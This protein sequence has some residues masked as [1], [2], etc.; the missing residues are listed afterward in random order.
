MSKYDV[1]TVGSSTID[2]F[3]HTDPGQSELLNVHNHADVAYPLGA[4][5]LIKELNFFTG[6]GGTN[7]AVAFSRLGLKSAFLGMV[8]N[9]D[10]GN[11]I[12]KNLSDEKV[13][14]IGKQSGISGY[15]VILDSVHD[16]RTIFTFKGCNDDFDLR[17]IELKSLDAGWF[18]FSSMM[19]H[20][21]SALEKLSDYAHK[22]NIKI[23]FNPSLYLAKKGKGY[24]KNVLKNCEILTYAKEEAQELLS[25]PTENIFIL[26][27]E[28]SKLGPKIVAITDGKNGANCYDSYENIFYSAKPPNNLKIVETTG[29]GDAFA[30]GF[31]AAKIL[32][33]GTPYAMK[34]GMINAESLISGL[35]AKTKLLTSIAFQIAEKNKRP[36]IKTAGM[37]INQS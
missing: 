3:A 9:D 26:L 30:S 15:S 11:V 27:Q 7:T 20:G 29:A 37:Q 13:D 4:K 1:I 25:N 6:G 16:D 8:G 17:G 33:K 2:V 21:F 10:N 14:F 36:I 24:M 18:Y 19:N 34:L 22:K 31:V 12:L 23:A 35:G 28:S 32:G 5:I